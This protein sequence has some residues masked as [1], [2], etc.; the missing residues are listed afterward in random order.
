MYIAASFQHINKE[1]HRNLEPLALSM[2]PDF[3]ESQSQD[4]ISFEV[5]A[6]LSAFLLDACNQRGEQLTHFLV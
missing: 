1:S 4:L 5:P 6:F 3:E 2:D